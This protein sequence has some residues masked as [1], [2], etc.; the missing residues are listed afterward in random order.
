MSWEKQN[1][2]AFLFVANLLCEIDHGFEVKGVLGR[3]NDKQ[4]GDPEGL[5]VSLAAKQLAIRQ[6]LFQET[7]FFQALS[8]ER[9]GVFNFDRIEAVPLV[10]AAEFNCSK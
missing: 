7:G 3:K 2:F 10:R 5:H 9:I 6:E 4:I 1:E 8:F